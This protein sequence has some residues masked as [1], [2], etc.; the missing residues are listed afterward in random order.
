MSEVTRWAPM[1]PDERPL[2]QYSVAVLIPIH[3]GESFIRRALEAVHNQTHKKVRVIAIDDASTDATPRLLEEYKDCITVLKSS[4]K[5]QAA[6]LNVGLRYVTE[7]FVAL[8]DVDDLWTPDKISVQLE[9][10]SK[11]PC[12][13]IVTDFAR[14]DPLLHDW[15][16]AWDTE[17]YQ[18]V[19]TGC[20]FEALLQENFI[21]RSSV[22]VPTNVLKDLNG[23]DE[24]I[25]G[26]DD[27][28]MWLRIAEK[29]QILAIR[30]VCCFKSV[31]KDAMSLSLKSNL[32]RVNMWRKWFKYLRHR[33][34]KHYAIAKEQLCGFMFNYAYLNYRNKGGNR[35]VAAQYF[36]KCFLSGRREIK[37]LLLAIYCVILFFTDR[38]LPRRLVK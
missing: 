32:S 11:N 19:T 31:H 2:S 34:P 38:L 6:A 33:D 8:L 21:L 29:S 36:V 15:K 4:A 17:G 23:F 12:S 14:G 9:A 16:S 20:A 10:W 13:L 26:T 3:N 28:D 30:K 37:A 27:L 7:D 25:S 35:G 5:N 24:S 1:I 18:H 22:L